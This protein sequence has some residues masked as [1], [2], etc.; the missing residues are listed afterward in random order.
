M[1]QYGYLE[2]GD[3]AR[4]AATNSITCHSVLKENQ[5][6]T[7]IFFSVTRGVNTCMSF[8]KILPIQFSPNNF[9]LE[10]CGTVMLKDCL[11]INYDL[12]GSFLS[13]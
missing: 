13:K 8:L 6:E 12:G 5:S 9:I 10:G 3:Q 11:L 7:G 1:D 4:P 2:L